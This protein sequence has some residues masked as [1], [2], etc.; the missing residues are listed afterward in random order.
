MKLEFFV[1]GTAR[2]AGSKS[3]F[4]GKDG[5]V[6][7]THSGKF[8]KEWMNTVRYF[9]LKAMDRQCVIDKPVRLFVCFDMPRP[10][11]HFGTGRNAGKL[12]DS[13]PKYCP[14]KPDL[15][16]LVRAVEDAITRVV[17]RDDALVVQQHTV[18]RYIANG[19][20]IGAHITIETLE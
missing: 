15:T 9:A 10:K 20:P 5:R 14:K 6:H 8:T 1:P 18:K 3:A 16:K 7:V 19:E 12:K 4:K 17:W 2:T 13:A 11:G